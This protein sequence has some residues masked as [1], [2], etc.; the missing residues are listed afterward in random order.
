MT[1]HGVHA[2]A[3]KKTEIQHP[4][5]QRLSSSPIILR[6]LDDDASQW[7]LYHDGGQN[8]GTIVNVSAPSLDGNALEQT[9][10]QGDPY[11]GLHMYRTL[12]QMNAT[13][14]KL[15]LSFYFTDQATI[16][17]LEFTVDSWHQNQRM[18]WALQWEQYGDGTLQQGI[19]PTWRLWT[20]Q[21]WQ[22]MGITQP[23]SLSTWHTLV[24]SGDIFHGNV[25]YRSFRC[26]DLG[27]PLSLV[28]PPTSSSGEKVVVGTQ[29]DGNSH[30]DRAQAYFDQVNLSVQ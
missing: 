7:D 14:F 11:S 21:S 22:N 24:L 1:I 6:N 2:S 20:G 25:R 13:S 28:F 18:E 27:T 8:T 10:L 3:L 15:R 16:Q 30:E 12:P 29:I 19:S 5:I 23:L 26:D 17:G 4:T 9:L